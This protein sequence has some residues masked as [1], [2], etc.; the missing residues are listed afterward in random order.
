M[1]CTYS[2]NL[3]KKFTFT[4]TFIVDAGGNMFTCCWEVRKR[5]DVKEA[6]EEMKE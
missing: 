2:I 6:D 1:Y 5:V 3:H 4:K